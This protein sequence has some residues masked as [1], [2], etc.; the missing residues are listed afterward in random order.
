MDPFEALASRDW[1]ERKHTVEVLSAGPTPRLA[2]K[3][4]EMVRTQHRDMGRLN[5]ALQLLSRSLA[6]VQAVQGLLEDDDADVRM[7]GILA[8]GQSGRPEA[9]PA[10]RRALR[11]PVSNVRT[12]A[13]E[14][15]G[16]VQA[17]EAVPDL[18]QF[19]DADDFFEAF[20][21]VEA[22]G[23]IGDARA[24]P[25]LLA[26]IH[27]ELLG[28]AVVG[29]LGA[30]GD[31]RAVEPVL[32]WLRAGGTAPV[33]ACALSAVFASPVAG[34]EGRDYVR[35]ATQ[36]G[37][38]EAQGRRVLEALAGEWTTS[39]ALALA[40]AR[41]ASWLGTLPALTETAIPLLIDLLADLDSREIAA[42]GLLE[43]GP[44]VVPHLTA[45]LDGAD[46]DVR[47]QLVAL[48]GALGDCGLVAVLERMLEDDDPYV[49][50][51]ALGAW[52]RLSGS[53]NLEPLLVR[54]RHP[55][56]LVRQMAVTALSTRVEPDVVERLLDR[57]GEAEP[58]ERE[59][60]IRLLSLSPDLRARRRVLQAAREEQ[61]AVRRVAVEGLG[62]RLHDDAEAV[63]VVVEALETAPP[64]VRGVA[65]RVL[66]EAPAHLARPSLR[67]ALRDT[68]SWTRLHACK[69]L[70]RL[71]A[72]EDVALIGALSRDA[73]PYVRAVVAET[74]GW[75]GGTT[76]V[77]LVC[78]LVD[79]PVLDVRL[80]ALAA[81][82][83]S[84]H[85]DALAPLLRS[86]SSN[87]PKVREAAML[88]LARHGSS[89]ALEALRQAALNPATCRAA[90]DAL[91][92][93][94]EP[95]WQMLVTLLEASDALTDAVRNRLLPLG[96]RAHRVLE[97]G[98]RT[99]PVETRRRIAE[100]LSQSP[101]PGAG[102]LLQQAR[103]DEDESVRT[104]A[105]GGL[106]GHG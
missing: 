11:D 18:L 21:A 99:A 9:I 16:H 14:A 95:G 60:I 48:L 59:S 93:G 97:E 13:I 25:V 90:L 105:S 46:S 30:I 103:E 82:G 28:E 6:G 72:P 33:A 68:D 83:E 12:H 75:M 61:E 56:A 4:V 73:V 64:S 53:E 7:Y 29:A 39:R 88:A 87:A 50:A 54:L 91:Q 8:L 44:A 65:A 98:L 76:A 24:V 70:G 38:T 69:A 52:A 37:L 45:A 17:W 80:A 55:S 27:D 71:G 106:P 49:V 92:G 78:R 47:Y 1:R 32:A 79:D 22:L 62:R 57:R 85:A 5:A 84:R 34:H 51:V 20:P 41:L 10:L 86:V 100:L 2:E 66:T 43:I 67:A 3:L 96:S 102:R 81:L 36:G 35:T 19:V 31:A 23:R 74:L 42:Q 40:T 89:A 15:L 94:A 63:A 77:D 58:A 101:A 26:H 104:A